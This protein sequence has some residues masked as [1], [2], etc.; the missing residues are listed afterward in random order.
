MLSQ[1]TASFVFLYLLAFYLSFVVVGGERLPPG[2]RAQSDARLT[3]QR[4][5]NREREFF[6]GAYVDREFD[7]EI[8]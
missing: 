4:G 5:S 6:E 7:D 1:V 8:I 2:L 3:P